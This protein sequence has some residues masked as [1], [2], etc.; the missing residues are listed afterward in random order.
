MDQQLRAS[1]RGKK[2]TKRELRTNRELHLLVVQL[3]VRLHN[4]A[5]ADGALLLVL[6][7]EDWLGAL[8]DWAEV[9]ALDVHA[10][11]DIRRWSA[12]G[13]IHNPEPAGHWSPLGNDYVAHA[14]FEYLSTRWS[15]EESRPTRDASLGRD[16]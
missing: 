14:V 10:Q 9:E 4:L 1:A 8:A 16:F 11:V 3:L 5:Q 6:T 15:E 12:K 13:E 2:E 7:D